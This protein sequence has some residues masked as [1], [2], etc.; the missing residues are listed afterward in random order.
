M[1]QR[2]IFVLAG[3]ITVFSAMFIQKEVERRSQIIILWALSLAAYFACIKFI[4]I[5]KEVCLHKGRLFGKDIHKPYKTEPVPESLGIVVGSVY[6][7][8]VVLFQS[9]SREMLGEYNAS[10]SAICFMLL[11]G[12]MDDVFDIRWRIKIGFS[13]LA[14]LPLLVAYDGPTKFVIPKPL[15]PIVGQETMELGIF[16]QGYMA[17]IMVFC[18]NSINIHAGIN[19]LETGQSVIIAGSVLIHNLIELDGPFGDHHMLSLI[20]VLPF[21]ATSSALM[22]YNWYPADVFVGDSFTYFSGMT[23]AVAGVT[24]H[25]SKTL[26]LF[27][28][29]QLFNFV[30]SLPQLFGLIPC[31][32]HRLPEYN[33]KD[34][35]LY[36]T[37]NFN[38]LNLYLFFS[39]PR[40]EGRLAAELAVLQILCSMLGFAV[41]Y[42]HT[43]TNYFY[44]GN[45]ILRG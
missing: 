1:T 39:G 24:G 7:V 11:L 23:L 25:F 22:Y 29:P 36:P 43:L 31:P 20:L 15:I 9:V 30:I 3:M 2:N 6:L 33:K 10:I 5:V 26:L 28:L 12:F 40:N 4:P 27:F 35:L 21:F 44:D 14:T 8:V 34:G 42:S 17:F 38:L 37:Y 45:Y 13:F 32:K 18:T 19:G 41:R 16:Y